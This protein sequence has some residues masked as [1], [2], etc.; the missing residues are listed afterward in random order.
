M[1][2]THLIENIRFFLL[3]RFRASLVYI[4]NRPTRCN[5]KQSTYYSANSLYMFRVSTTPSLAWPR[6]REVAAQ[7]IWPVTE[8]VVTILCTPD[9]GCGWHPKHADWTCRIISR[10][11]FVAS[12]WTIININ[13]SFVPLKVYCFFSI[14]P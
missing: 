6:P 12:R 9:D 8:A 2:P 4:N 5:T 3:L 1:Q 7:K 11:L 10:L 13:I 14:E